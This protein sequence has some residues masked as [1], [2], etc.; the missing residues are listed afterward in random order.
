MEE[1]PLDAVFMT[2]AQ[3]AGGIEPLLQEFFSFLNRR[4][5]FYVVDSNPKRPMGFDNGVAEAMVLVPRVRFRFCVA[6]C[7]NP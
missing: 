2:A 7:E 6:R 3:R 4:T 1:R 5:D